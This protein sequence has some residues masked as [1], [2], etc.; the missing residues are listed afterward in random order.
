MTLMGTKWP[1]RSAGIVIGG[2]GV[3]VGRVTVRDNTVIGGAD[4]AV[5]I[6]GDA[7]ED[8]DVS[9]TRAIGTRSAVSVTGETLDRVTVE[10]TLHTTGRNVALAANQSPQGRG[11][12]RVGRNDPCPCGS[13]AKWKKC[14][15]R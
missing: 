1:P 13:G 5:A 7:L 9:G 3:P 12:E 6:Y 2:P 11:P 10:R 4:V 14:C 15:G 8:I